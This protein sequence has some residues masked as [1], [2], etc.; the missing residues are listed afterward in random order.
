VDVTSVA[1]VV[2]ALTAIAAALFSGLTLYL[3]GRRE[4]RKWI[5]ESV[6]G[7]LVQLLDASF[8]RPSSRARRLLLDPTSNGNL[9]Q[10]KQ[11]AEEAHRAQNDAL[12]KLRLLAARPV[13]QAAEKLHSADEAVVETVLGDG[14]PAPEPEWRSAR[15]QQKIAREQLINEA[16]KMLQLNKGAEIMSTRD[17]GT[18]SGRGF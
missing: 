6:L 18:D 15:A 3:S 9:A 16:R 12:T 2:G 13:V 4:T 7:A 8:M 17:K 11:R 10:F 5:R 1:A 14:G